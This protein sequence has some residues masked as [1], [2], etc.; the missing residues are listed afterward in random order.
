MG[1]LL[2][3]QKQANAKWAEQLAEALGKT[4]RSDVCRF[5]CPVCKKGSSD[6]A[7]QISLDSVSGK[8]SVTCFRCRSSAADIAEAAGAP[9]PTWTSTGRST[10]SDGSFGFSHI[11]SYRISEDAVTVPLSPSGFI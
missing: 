11:G 3:R 10:T 7:G 8:A 4:L 2:E 6:T 1:T 9:E 5:A